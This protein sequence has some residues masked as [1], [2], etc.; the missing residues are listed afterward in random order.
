M[1]LKSIVHSKM[2][3]VKEVFLI[4]KDLQYYSKDVH[5]K[6]FWDGK[7]GAMVK[8]FTTF[9]AACTALDSLPLYEFMMNSYFEIEKLYI[10]K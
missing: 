1:N 3:I 2:K 7:T 8:Q 4:R 5:G 10:K 6:I 9:E